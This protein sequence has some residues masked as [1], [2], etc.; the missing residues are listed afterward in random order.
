[1]QKSTG[2]RSTRS[3]AAANL[4][5]LLGSGIITKGD[6]GAAGSET[7]PVER[8]EVQDVQQE[9]MQQASPDIQEKRIYYIALDY[10][11]DNPYQPREDIPVDDDLRE[12]A[13]GIKA[14]GLLGA[15]PMRK[16]PEREGYYQLAFGHR[17]REACRL[18]GKES[19]PVTIED[20]NNA[21]MAALAAIENIHRKDLTHLQ[22]GRLFLNM[23]R[24]GFTQEEIAESVKK[25]RGYVVN[26][27]RLAD[28]PA[29]I[30]Q[31]VEEKPDSLRSIAYLVKVKEPDDRALLI[32]N[33]KTGSLRT[34]DLSGDIGELLDLLR[35]SHSM[36]TQANADRN[37]KDNLL[38]QAQNVTVVSQHEDSPVGKE[39]GQKTPGVLYSDGKGLLDDTSPGSVEQTVNR[40][41]ELSDN[42]GQRLDWVQA[43]TWSTKLRAI[44]RS[45]EAYE[46]G[47]CER[48][49]IS[50][51]EQDL[52]RKI[53]AR[54]MEICSKESVKKSVG[55]NTT[56]PEIL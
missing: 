27:L 6:T 20:L 10:L 8:M 56:L 7:L 53:Q 37:S 32:D 55:E 41:Y 50:Q 2:K 13:E 38:V 23:Q 45:L 42:D 39:T 35:A 4:Q 1:M 40:S 44:L 14:H 16:H 51:A 9:E 15:L 49:K 25:D 17:R 21:A 48:T 36:P 43:R 18:A 33:L 28:A 30:Q 3:Q 31:F 29:D 52:L 24:E 5:A 22:L 34:D 12:M 26:R 19:A 11:L 47:L 46:N 54:Y